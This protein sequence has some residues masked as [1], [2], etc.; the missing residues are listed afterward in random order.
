MTSSPKD[1]AAP[2]VAI[3]FDGVIVEEA[4]PAIG[5]PIPLA[6]EAIRALDAAGYWIIVNTCREADQPTGQDALAYLATVGIPFDAYNVNLP[7]RIA[8]FGG[9]AR[10]ISADLYVDDRNFPGGFDG[11]ASVFEALGLPVPVA[12]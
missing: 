2:V 6:A 11:W 8:R 3:D 7:H 4:W 5:P 9:D 10:K 1:P 12:A